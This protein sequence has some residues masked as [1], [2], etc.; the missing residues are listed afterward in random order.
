MVVYLPDN[1][2]PLRLAGCFCPGCDYDLKGA[3]STTCPECGTMFDPEA[4]RVAGGRL[5][6]PFSLKEKAWIGVGAVLCV[7]SAGGMYLAPTDGIAMALLGAAIL[8]V[9]G[10]GFYVWLRRRV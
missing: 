7:G 4:L 2:D 8:L 5:Q 1:N 9:A 3:R 10:L 6:K